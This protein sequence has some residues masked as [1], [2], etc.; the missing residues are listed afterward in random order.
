MFIKLTKN[1]QQKLKDPQIALK[2]REGEVAHW[3]KHQPSQSRDHG[4]EPHMCRNH[5]LS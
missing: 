4:F 1:K 5:D 3:F 2:W